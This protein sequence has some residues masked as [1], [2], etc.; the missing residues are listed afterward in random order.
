[1]K[2]RGAVGIG[3]ALGL[4]L[5]L[6]LLLAAGATE[7]REGK[8]LLTGGVSTID[9]AAGG[10]L[11]PWAVTGSYASVGEFGA[12]AYATGVRTGDYGLAGYGAALSY[13]ER[14]EVSLARQDLDTRN[15]LAPLGLAGL[16]LKQDIVGLNLRLA[17]DA[18]LDS[19]SLVPQVAVGVLHKRS[20][21]GALE[22]TLTGALGAKAS[23]T[24][25]YVSATKLFLEPGLL[26]NLT[27][28]VS[29][30][31]QGGLLGFGGARPAGGRVQPEV[32][33]AW[34]LRRDLAV[35]A[36]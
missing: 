29:K 12:T 20:D 14:I 18:V 2:R 31:N 5:G 22:A 26:I 3:F 33:L 32:S 8:L 10:G 35:G 6:A 28:R 4:S 15:N 19:D 24:E 9:G 23:G 21:S 1:V 17:G 27:L 25:L 36:E 11:T 7:A 34:L 30:A 16:H 13:S